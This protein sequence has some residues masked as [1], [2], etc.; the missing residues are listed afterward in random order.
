M[1]VSYWINL[2]V[3]YTCVEP[4]DLGKRSI[5]ECIAPYTAVQLRVE[6]APDV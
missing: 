6:V 3:R 2:G 4:F 5:W 1:I